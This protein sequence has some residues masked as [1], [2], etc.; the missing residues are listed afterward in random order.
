MD[1][2][3]EVWAPGGAQLVPLRGERL[4]LGRGPGNDVVLA[5]DPSVSSLHAVVDPI[6]GG[7]CI[8]DLGSRNGTFVAG[9]AVLG[10]RALRHGDEL[11]LGRTRLVFRL[12]APAEVDPTEGAAPPPEVTRRERDVLLALCRP[13]FRG[14]T[15]SEPASLREIADELVVTEAAVKQH[16]ARLYEKFGIAADAGRKRVL[17]ANDAVRRGAVTMADLR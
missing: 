11:R 7:W 3:L 4:T 12:A 15:F 8:R 14:Q 17:L 1:G 10:D 6:G 5:H 13:L 16:L 2:F 9:E